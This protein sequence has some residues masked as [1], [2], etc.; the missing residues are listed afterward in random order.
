MFSTSQN[1]QFVSLFKQ[2]LNPVT[3]YSFID[4]ISMFF[5]SSHDLW[6]EVVDATFDENKVFLE[7][8]RF[9]LTVSKLNSNQLK[10]F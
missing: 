3:S 10:I 8:S 6:F 4:N 9:R 1:P 7:S 5:E 2:T